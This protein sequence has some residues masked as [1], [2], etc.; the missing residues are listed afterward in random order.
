ME[1]SDVAPAALVLSPH[2]RSGCRPQSSAWRIF[3]GEK[4]SMPDA[5]ELAVYLLPEPLKVVFLDGIIIEITANAIDTCC[6]PRAARFI[7][8]NHRPSS[9]GLQSDVDMEAPSAAGSGTVEKVQP[10]VQEEKKAKKREMEHL[11][12]MLEDRED[13]HTFPTLFFRDDV[14]EDFGTH[15]PE[16][17]PLPTSAPRSPR[18]TGGSTPASPL[19]VAT[20]ASPGSPLPSVTPATQATRTPMRRGFFFGMRLS[21]YEECIVTYVEKVRKQLS[22][23]ADSTINPCDDF[24]SHVCG[25]W[26]RKA[27]GGTFMA[28]AKKQ[29]IARRHELL[30]SPPKASE[31]N[32]PVL[33]T[34]H[35]F[36]T[37]CLNMFEAPVVLTKALHDLFTALNVSV[38]EWLDETKW[39]MLFARCFNL[40]LKNH[41]HTVFKINLRHTAN[42]SYYS[43]EMGLSFYRKMLRSVPSFESNE[44]FRRVLEK[45]GETAPRSEVVSE[46]IQMDNIWASRT[47]MKG[48]PTF[49]K[50]VAALS[51]GPFTAN[52]WGPRFAEHGALNDTAVEANYFGR[53]CA[54]MEAVFLN[55]STQ[56][57]PLYLLALMA[58]QVLTF[59]FQLAFVSR[60]KELL[61]DVCLNGA[62][63]L[64]GE[65]WLHA[66]S[67]FLS[68]KRPSVNDIRNFTNFSGRLQRVVLEREWMTHDDRVMCANRL[69]GYQVF[70]F[71]DSAMSVQSLEC[72]RFGQ[73]DKSLSYKVLSDTFV[74]N[75]VNIYK[76]QL[77]PSCLR[78]KKTDIPARMQD[79]MLGTDIVID[80][81]KKSIIIP[82][83]LGAQP[84][85]YVGNVEKFINI[86]TVTTLVTSLGAKLASRRF[87]NFSVIGV[88]Q[89]DQRPWS[90]E[91]L[92]KYK[93]VSHCLTEGYK[94][95]GKPLSDIAIDDVFSIM[96]GIEVAKKYEER[97]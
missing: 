19:T 96:N 20:R 47:D 60:S 97:V 87:A 46:L 76:V 68:L 84:L 88:N 49:P 77:S 9:I 28:D 85:F 80:I 52:V 5:T 81:S 75:V 32:S 27:E 92:G 6:V 91:T 30:V 40:S 14:T 50:T 3:V 37:S 51:C 10:A 45:I 24:Y 7:K 71:P 93:G 54:F 95:P 57:R 63:H 21:R 22:E 23:Y 83:F 43:L 59:D 15:V 53:T 86:A 55:A 26:L 65:M 4:W 90:D 44:Y 56:A 62:L 8:K 73:G 17:A 29:F 18:T 48:A 31:P 94:I 2:P 78:N 38:N 61:M 70:T 13:L 36:Y 72:S 69:S 42:G 58:A 39:Q 12:R 33:E 67:M 34:A 66:M 82:Q 35:V 89:S 11:E 64:F 79:A 74:K 25:H 1:C 41:F 16:I